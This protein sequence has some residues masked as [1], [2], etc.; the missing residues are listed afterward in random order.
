MSDH[1][2]GP[3]NDNEIRALRREMVTMALRAGV[4]ADAEDLVQD[5]LVALVRAEARV[6][7]SYAF[8]A[9]YR[10][11]ALHWR[12]HHRRG[13]LQVSDLFAWES[14]SWPEVDH[15]QDVL[16][17]DGALAVLADGELPGDL[18]VW[19]PAAPFWASEVVDAI[20]KLLDELGCAGQVSERHSRRLR[21]GWV[22]SLREASEKVKVELVTALPECSVESRVQVRGADPDADRQELQRRCDVLRGRGRSGRRSAGGENGHKA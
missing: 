17:L 2:S 11:I 10:R 6:A 19:S 4:G 12:R 13:A 14:A 16:R 15:L 22:R 9:L 5:C 7:R 8:G 3:V 18:L 21:A 1:R 20:E